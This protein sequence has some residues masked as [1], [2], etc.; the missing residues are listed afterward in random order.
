V[1]SNWSSY[2]KTLAYPSLERAP[3]GPYATPRTAAYAWFE[4]NQIPR[5]PIS[6]RIELITGLNVVG[7]KAAEH[8]QI[9]AYAFGGHVEL[10]YDSVVIILNKNENTYLQH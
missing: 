10:H 1:N 4:D 5:T 6:R 2:L 7:D 8:L 9:A 3:S